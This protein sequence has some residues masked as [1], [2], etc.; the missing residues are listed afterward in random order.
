MTRVTSETT[1]VSTPTAGTRPPARFGALVASE[2]IKLWSLRSTYWALGLGV[3]A[4]IGINVYSTLALRRLLPEW[5]AEARESYNYM[6]DAL[7]QAPYLLLL[8]AAGIIGA[9]SMAGE[10]ATGMIRTT[11]VAVPARRSVV[12][13]KA[14]VISGATLAVGIVVATTSVGLTQVLLSGQDAGF[15][16]SNKGVPT[17]L[18]ASAVVVPVCALVGMGIGVLI[19]HTAGAIFGVFTVIVILPQLTMG[20][21][22]SW[23]V[24]LNNS[25]L[26]SA[27]MTLRNTPIRELMP[28]ELFTWPVG[29][30]WL[31]LAVWP[32]VAVV[33]AV[34][35]T[36][37]RE[38]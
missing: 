17:A 22:Y 13:A 5:S 6:N 26:W 31:V 10:Y 33:A 29:A 9:L 38:V 32:L 15:A 7:G 18:V 1:P 16:I 8:I 11:F 14:T 36:H 19:R 24:D 12:I 23:V 37:R 30:S 20:T 21:T 28:A 27:W 34:V 25:T 4:V 2:W 35:V 3:V